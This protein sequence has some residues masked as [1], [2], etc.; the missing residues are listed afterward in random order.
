MMAVNPRVTGPPASSNHAS[1]FHARWELHATRLRA[2][3][4]V[5]EIV[6]GPTTPSLYFWALQASFGQG[7]ARRGAG[8]I[9]LQH[10]PSYPGSGAVNWG[11][12]HDRSTG[13]GVLDGSSSSLQSSL[14]NPNTFDYPW[15][16]GRRYRLEINRSDPGR[17]LGSVTDLASGD[18]T[19]V[20]ELYVDAEHLVSPMVWS[21]V[22]ADCDAP[23][24]VVR[25]SSP[26]AVGT[27]GQFVTPTAVSLSYQSERDGGCS[28]TST[29]C[30]DGWLVQQT[31]TERVHGH[32]TRLTW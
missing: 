24:V 17:W 5:L 2:V 7:S 22:F 13:G 26:S 19:V 18:R 16:V 28:N 23:P 29:T 6:S 27:D 10:H 9:G 14:G 3:S 12:Y 25:W 21:E 4:V 20:R 31:S 32:G 11:G 15:E 8:H 30:E 1:S